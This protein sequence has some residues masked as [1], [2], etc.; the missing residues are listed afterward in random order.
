MRKTIIILNIIAAI[1]LGACGR[2]NHAKHD[3][4]R[5]NGYSNRTY[6]NQDQHH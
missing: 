6:G 5:H 2:R 4:N 3:M 1:A